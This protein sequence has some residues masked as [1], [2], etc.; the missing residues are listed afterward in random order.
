MI[1][2]IQYKKFE[3]VVERE[4]DYTPHYQLTRLAEQNY[5][6]YSHEAREAN[7]Y[8][9]AGTLKALADLRGGKMLSSELIKK[10]ASMDQFESITVSGSAIALKKKASAEEDSNDPW[11]VVA[12]NGVEYF[13]KADEDTEEKE[14]HVTKTAA[15]HTPEHTYIVRIAAHNLNELNK[16][17]TAGLGADVCPD[18][19]TNAITIVIQSPKQE[20]EVQNDMSKALEAMNVFLPKENVEV[21]HDNCPCCQKNQHCI[22]PQQ[23]T[24]DNKGINT[25]NPSADNATHP[26]IPEQ[27][28]L[29][30]GE[31]MVVTPESPK[32]S[33]ASSK[34]TLMVYANAHYKNFSIFDTNKK[35]IAEVKNGVEVTDNTTFGESLDAFL[36]REAANDP[37][38]K[39]KA[40]DMNEKI[41]YTDQ[42]G[43][44]TQNPV[45]GGKTVK[46]NQ[47]GT[48]EISETRSVGASFDLD[49]AISKAAAEMPAFM[50]KEQDD[51][52]KKLEE[53]RDPNEKP[54]S[55]TKA[56]ND[57]NVKRWKGMREDPASH[58]FVVYITE[59]EEHIFDSIEPAVAFLTRA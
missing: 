59:T 34:E 39:V 7:T 42:E 23:F 4:V 43:N 33:V 8:N 19:G 48:S 40:E 46:R 15:L 25:E 53:H 50:E 27:P 30:Q 9:L 13:V 36:M 16:I 14:S 58:K 18:L 21:F 32:V 55:E 49:D 37:D 41:E 56:L 35:V 54:T 24:E 10:V 17:A 20:A 38:L 31:L 6:L 1:D 26:I 5:Q 3:P 51:L 45:V 2:E 44:V 12:I 57:D 47:D 11:K 52:N 29:N 28:K 22:P